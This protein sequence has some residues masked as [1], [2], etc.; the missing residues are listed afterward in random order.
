MAE[1]R[2][3]IANPP[4]TTPIGLNRC[5]PASPTKVTL[6]S[7]AVP[8]V[9]PIVAVIGGAGSLPSKIA[10][11]NSRPL[12]PAPRVS[13]SIGSSHVIV[14]V[15]ALV[16]TSFIRSH[17]LLELDR[18]SLNRCGAQPPDAGSGDRARERQARHDL[19]AGLEG[20]QDL[21]LRA[22]EN[23]AENCYSEGGAEVRRHSVDAPAGRES[24]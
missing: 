20:S 21:P 12:R 19:P 2:I 22:A 7:S 23:G 15:R 1:S 13:A 16:S 10:C 8:P 3:V 14:R 4:W 5:S 9:K 17:C 6:P 24:R 11:M 18:A